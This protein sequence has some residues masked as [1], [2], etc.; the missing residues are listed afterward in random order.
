MHSRKGLGYAYYSILSSTGRLRTVLARIGLCL[1]YLDLVPVGYGACIDMAMLTR[2]STGRLCCLHGYADSDD[3]TAAAAQ[4]GGGCCVPYCTRRDLDPRVAVVSNRNQLLHSF[5]LPSLQ[6]AAARFAASKAER[7]RE[8]E[9]ER[10]VSKAQCPP[11]VLQR[12]AASSSRV[13]SPRFSAAS[14]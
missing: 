2:P 7:D 13:F 5:L 12:D 10:E 11:P 3:E 6:D 14:R 4:D 1:L 8:R 9:R